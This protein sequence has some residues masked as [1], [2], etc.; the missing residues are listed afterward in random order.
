MWVKRV[1]AI[2]A[3]VSLAACGTSPEVTAPDGVPLPRSRPKAFS[4]PAQAELKPRR[5]EFVDFQ[6]KME[7]NSVLARRWTLC[8]LLH[9]DGLARNTE[10][11]TESI[12]AAAFAACANE[13]DALTK[14]I[15]GMRMR[16][17]VTEEILTRI[18]A[19]DREQLVAR[20][21]SRRQRGP[22][23]PQD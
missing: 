16:P 12:V 6:E 10:Q 1:I 8:K 20:I 19:A 21:L 4:S 13:E 11:P 17:A 23:K 15:A 5:E 14:S 9:A 3:F 18:R 22:E 7:R 2:G